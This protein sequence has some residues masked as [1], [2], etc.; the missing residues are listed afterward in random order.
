MNK[1]AILIF[2][3]VV[4]ASCI[5]LT[6]SSSTAKDII[7][8][9]AANDKTVLNKGDT[10]VY[11][12]NYNNVAKYC[13]MQKKTGFIWASISRKDGATSHPWEK[14]ELEISLLDSVGKVMTENQNYIISSSHFEVPIWASSFYFFPYPD[15]IKI[16]NY[17]NGSTFPGTGSLSVNWYDKS[18]L[19]HQ[20]S[21]SLKIMNREFKNVIYYNLDTSSCNTPARHVVAFYCNSQCGLLG[22]KYSGG[23]IFELVE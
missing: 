11:K 5:K 9:L 12:S 14:W 20:K 22:F 15:F 3:T 6:D 13:V 1:F 10:L 7:H 23:E 18:I 2:L 19:N 17:A 8:S 16:R 4:F 21:T